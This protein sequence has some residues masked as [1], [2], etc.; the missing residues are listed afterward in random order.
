LGFE[1]YSLLFG[2]FIGF[3]PLDW[4]LSKMIEIMKLTLE[5]L[6]NRGKFFRKEKN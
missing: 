1:D 2:S 6:K 3:E 4:R 5:T